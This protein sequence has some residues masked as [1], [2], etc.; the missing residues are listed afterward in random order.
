MSPNQPVKIR[1]DQNNHMD[2]SIP[3]T[4]IVLSSHKG[5]NSKF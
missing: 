4:K 1:N 2:L 5:E 3:V